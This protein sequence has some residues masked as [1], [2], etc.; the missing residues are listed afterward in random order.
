MEL[1]IVVKPALCSGDK[2]QTVNGGL[3]RMELQF[4]S[5]HIRHDTRL[6]IPN[7]IDQKHHSVADLTGSLDLILCLAQR[8][9]QRPILIVQLLIGLFQLFYRA[10]TTSRHQKAQTPK[11]KSFH[12]HFLLNA[13]H[14]I[15][16]NR[17]KQH[18]SN[19]P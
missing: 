9:F 6:H 3:F 5:A 17:K 15:H 8:A 1:G 7:L 12:R 10:T 18:H 16:H 19:L 11:N 2:S 4:N 14:E 13:I